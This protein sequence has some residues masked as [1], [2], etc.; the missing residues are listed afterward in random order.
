[1]SSVGCPALPRCGGGGGP[2]CACE[3][4]AVAL[5]AVGQRADIAQSRPLPLLSRPRSLRNY[6][7]L[8]AITPAIAMVDVDLLPSASLMLGLRQPGGWVSS[9]PGRP[10]QRA[11]VR[12]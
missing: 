4:A 12:A 8:A 11:R 3:A 9:D 2:P 10:E 1:M 5:L 6:A 7:T